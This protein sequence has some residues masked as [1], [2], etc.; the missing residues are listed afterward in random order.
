MATRAVNLVCTYAAA[1]EVARA[2][3]RVDPEKPASA[4]LATRSGF[5]YAPQLRDADGTRF[6]RYIRDLRAGRSCRGH[7]LVGG[8]AA[9][10]PGEG[11]Q[12]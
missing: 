7:D 5:T 4:A 12:A 8:E 11:V 3:I 2:V 10:G 9:Q 6:D 1:Q